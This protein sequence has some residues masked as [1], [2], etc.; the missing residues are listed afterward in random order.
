MGIKPDRMS[1]LNDE[2]GDGRLKETVARALAFVRYVVSPGGFAVTA[3]LLLAFR[4]MGL[5]ERG[6]L[7][8]DEVSFHLAAIRYVSVE[9]LVPLYFQSGNA[10]TVG[11]GLLAL[12]LDTSF[13]SALAVTHLIGFLIVPFAYYYARKWEEDSAA[14]IAAALIGLNGA[15]LFWS[16]YLYGIMPCIMETFVA[17]CLFADFAHRV[18]FT[19]FYP[20]R[21]FTIGFICGWAFTTHEVAL[22]TTCAL[23]GAMA[24]Y[25]AWWIFGKRAGLRETIISSCSFIAGAISPIIFFNNVVPVYYYL[26]TGR[27]YRDIVVERTLDFSMSGQAHTYLGHLNHLFKLGSAFSSGWKAVYL[28]QA[29][30]LTALTAGWPALLLAAIGLYAAARSVNARALMVFPLVTFIYLFMGIPNS[31]YI[32]LRTIGPIL[33]FILLLS[34]VGARHLLA[35]VSGSP[36][37]AAGWALRAIMYPAI[38]WLGC[39]MITPGLD[40]AQ[41]Q[42]PAHREI[43]KFAAERDVKLSKILSAD[44]AMAWWYLRYPIPHV[45]N[46]TMEKIKSDYDYLVIQ[47]C[48]QMDWAMYLSVVKDAVKGLTPDYVIPNPLCSQDYLIAEF[49]YDLYKML[50]VAPLPNEFKKDKIYIYKTRDF[51]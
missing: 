4:M 38:L 33:P 10:F 39:A 44:H 19:R 8:V 15:I 48:S 35:S 25:F 28:K 45:P 20:A 51:K 24:I 26:T 9:N 22:V 1:A 41:K 29:L 49:S 46:L 2:K 23:S 18:E 50:T 36:H 12:G 14:W 16:Y 40:F 13:Q 27:D 11:R 34:A 30:E 31:N 21:F 7:Q 47:V 32:A 5:A 17:V 42:K 37:G 6:P 43:F 3:M